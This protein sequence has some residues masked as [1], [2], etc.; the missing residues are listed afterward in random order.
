[1]VQALGYARG[2]IV[3][4]S[5]LIAGT[6]LAIAFFLALVVASCARVDLVLRAWLAAIAVYVSLLVTARLTTVLPALRN[7]ELAFCIASAAAVVSL[8]VAASRAILNP[9]C[10]S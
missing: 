4:P 9:F 1:L 7:A 5:L 10:H 2:V 3:P 8:A 6:C